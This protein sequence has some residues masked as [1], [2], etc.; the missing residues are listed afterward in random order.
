[1]IWPLAGHPAEAGP[2]RELAKGFSPCI[3]SVARLL[4]HVSS[5][6]QQNGLET[7]NLAADSGGAVPAARQEPETL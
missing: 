6:A 4:K 7:A 2:V 1:M 3:L 5:Y